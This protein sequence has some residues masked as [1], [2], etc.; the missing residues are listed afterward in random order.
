MKLKQLTSTIAANH[1]A[2]SDPVKK[3]MLA[4]VDSVAKGETSNFSRFVSHQEKGS[5]IT[6]L[7]FT[8]RIWLLRRKQM[9]RLCRPHLIIRWEDGS[10]L[11]VKLYNVPKLCHMQITLF[12]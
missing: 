8:F 2:R 12:K 4:Y 10:L 5:A 1:K 9:T 7:L 6:K 11:E 3:T